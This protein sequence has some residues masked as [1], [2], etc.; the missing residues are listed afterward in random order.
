MLVQFYAVSQVF[1][2]VVLF[3]FPILLSPNVK[4]FL[5]NYLCKMPF[6]RRSWKMALIFALDVS[7]W[8]SPFFVNGCLHRA[9]VMT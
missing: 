5:I 2:V 9:S 6:V 1:F 8:L 7:V 4:D 3:Y